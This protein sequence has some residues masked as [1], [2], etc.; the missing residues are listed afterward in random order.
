MLCAI[1][2]L[3]F[4]TCYTQARQDLFLR[5]NLVRSVDTLFTDTANFHVAHRDEHDAIVYLQY[6]SSGYLL[7][8]TYF[9]WS[10]ED[11]YS[12]INIFY[13]ETGQ[14]E[15]M[16]LKKD[17]LSINTSY[18]IGGSLK[19]NSLIL[20]DANYQINP[21]SSVHEYHE[22]GSLKRR[23]TLNQEKQKITEYWDNGLIKID[24]YWI[25]VTGCFT[26]SYTEFD[27]SGKILVQ[28][29]YEKTDNL[30]I[31][32][33]DKVGVWKYYKNGKLVKKERF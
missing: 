14:I 28:G 23:Y 33:V 30:L 19:L 12:C 11:P 29:N 6:F 16:H 3:S 21:I 31:T 26:G 2:V 7:N 32:E 18:Y 24:A 9:Y 25:P 4:T 20:E 15:C 13:Y 8:T 10:D 27:S 1:V 5:E 22:N 17:T